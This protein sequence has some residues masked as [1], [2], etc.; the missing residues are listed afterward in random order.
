MCRRWWCERARAHAHAPKAAQSTHQN[1]AYHNTHF[2]ANLPLVPTHQDW[3]AHICGHPNA[4]THCKIRNRN[5]HSDSANFVIQHTCWRC[6]APRQ[7]S[8]CNR[9]TARQCIR[10]GPATPPVV[11]TS[12]VWWTR[13]HE[14]MCRTQTARKQQRHLVKVVCHRARLT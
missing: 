3:D 2:L 1:A 14:S 11:T 12:I 10:S 9:P 7:L 5:E 4:M 6:A 13:P 8:L